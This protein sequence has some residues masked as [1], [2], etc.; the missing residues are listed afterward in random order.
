MGQGTRMGQL[1]LGDTR[2]R[3]TRSH[4]ARIPGR[5]GR[6]G[7]FLR[8][9]LRGQN[10]TRALPL[11]VTMTP[12]GLS[13]IPANFPF[14]NTRSVGNARFWKR[15]AV[16]FFGTRVVFI[17]VSNDVMDSTYTLFQITVFR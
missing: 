17:R 5:C 14:I 2:R 7:R 15:Y 8:L 1:T 10:S 12:P 9:S 4:E 11:Y 6:G 16:V 13:Q 3:G